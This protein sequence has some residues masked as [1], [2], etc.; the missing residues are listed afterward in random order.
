MEPAL[1]EDGEVQTG[2]ARFTNSAA[3]GRARRADDDLASKRLQK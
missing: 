1:R 2:N 3:H